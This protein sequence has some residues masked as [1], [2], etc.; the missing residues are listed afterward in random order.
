LD[1][2]INAEFLPAGRRGAENAEKRYP[3]I[4]TNFDEFH[5]FLLAWVIH[6]L[7]SKRHKLII[8]NK[9]YKNVIPNLVRNLFIIEPETSSG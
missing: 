9:L 1:Y 5:E 6:E 8:N 4:N 7:L 3:R 2:L